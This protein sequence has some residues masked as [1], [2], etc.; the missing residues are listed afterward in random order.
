MVEVRVTTGFPE[1]VDHEEARDAVGDALHREAKWAEVKYAYFAR[2]CRRFE[3]QYEL[4]SDEF[5]ER[6]ESGELGD[7]QNYFD[8]Y[9][10]K[11]GRD[12]WERRSAI[13]SRAQV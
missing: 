1:G 9:A 3:A 5:M 10:A 6:F 4:T 12:L 11:R 7:D 8:W 2:V 13:L